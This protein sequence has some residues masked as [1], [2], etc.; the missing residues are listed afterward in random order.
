MKEGKKAICRLYFQKIC[1]PSIQ[2]RK[3]NFE[4]RPDWFR[5]CQIKFACHFYSIVDRVYASQRSS[6]SLADAYVTPLGCSLH[7]R[8]CQLFPK[9]GVCFSA[10]VE[11]KTF[12]LKAHKQNK[13]VV[14][15]T[16][17]SAPGEP[18]AL[19]VSPELRYERLSQERCSRLNP[20]STAIMVIFP[21]ARGKYYLIDKRDR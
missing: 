15:L 8:S 7:F 17:V 14:L 16:S 3:E 2:W 13:S 19:S 18:R 10:A 1:I 12:T 11:L 21:L 9:K 20:L 5:R 6:V 4:S